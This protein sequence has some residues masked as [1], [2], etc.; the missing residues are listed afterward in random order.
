VG[1]AGAPASLAAA[2]TVAARAAGGGVTAAAFGSVSPASRADQHDAIVA[3]SAS[4][5]ALAV[6]RSWSPNA[7]D[8][9]S[10]A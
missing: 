6:A 9:A 2:A 1:A 3:V 8:H 7:M 4:V 5:V 10:Y